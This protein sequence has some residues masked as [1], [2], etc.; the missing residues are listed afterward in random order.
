[1]FLHFIFLAAVFKHHVKQTHNFKDFDTNNISSSF[2]TA[3]LNL[4]YYGEQKRAYLPQFTFG[5]EA[6]S[7]ISSHFGVL[8][9][10]E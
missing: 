1:M 9:S 8:F 4:I 6:L 2:L 10:D 7:I 3:D 5:E